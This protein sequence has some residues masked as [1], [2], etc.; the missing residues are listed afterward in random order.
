MVACAGAG[1]VL[2]LLG[3]LLASV[4]GIPAEALFWSGWTFYVT[5]VA[6]TLLYEV[7]VKRKM[8]QKMKSRDEEFN[9]NVAKALWLL[10]LGAVLTLID[11][12]YLPIQAA[13]GETLNLSPSLD[14]TI[15]NIIVFACIFVKSGI[16]AP[17]DMLD[18]LQVLQE[19]GYLARRHGKR[20]A[21]PGQVNLASQ[22]CIVSFP[23]KYADE[24]WLWEVGSN[25]L[26]A[27]GEESGIIMRCHLKM[28]DTWTHIHT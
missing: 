25:A 21:F 23:G 5:V 2:A 6:A 20:I 1:F 28:E 4:P 22:H 7:H 8:F 24:T 14:F 17:N 19:L 26:P 16:L 13:E 27:E 9:R 15:D 3:G 10:R 11:G 12:I 18:Q